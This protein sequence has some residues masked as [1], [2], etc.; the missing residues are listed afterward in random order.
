MAA[1]AE[2]E[3]RF[4]G[5]RPPYGYRL[6]HTGP[7]PNPARAADGRRLHA[8]DVDE[9]AAAIVRRIFASYIGA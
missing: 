3:G 4:R 1:Q 5:G 7:H 6:I 9:A 2:T 8:L